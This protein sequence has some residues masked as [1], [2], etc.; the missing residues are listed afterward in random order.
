MD[1]YRIAPPPGISPSLEHSP[2]ALHLV[3]CKPQDVDSQ[4]Q[5]VCIQSRHRP[6]GRAASITRWSWVLQPMAKQPVATIRVNPLLPMC[7]TSVHLTKLGAWKITL[8]VRDR[9]GRTST[10]VSLPTFR[11]V[12]I[13]AIGDSLASGEGNPGTGWTDT[14]CHR[15]HNAWPEQVARNF[16]ENYQT[17]V[18]FLSYAC[19][20]ANLENLYRTYQNGAPPQVVAARWDIGAPKGSSTRRIDALLL[21]VGVNDLG[22]VDKQGRIEGFSSILKQCALTN[23]QRD[24]SPEFARLPGLYAALNQWIRA[25]LKVAHVYA[26]DYPAWIFTNAA[27]HFETCGVFDAMSN[28]DVS[29]VAT[30]GTASRPDPGHCGRQVQLEGH[31]DV[32]PTCFTTATAPAAPPGIA[33]GAI[34]TTSR[35]M[36]GGRRTPPI[37]VITG[38][39]NSCR[40][41]LRASSDLI[42]RVLTRRPRQRGRL[43]AP[44]HEAMPHRTS[45]GSEDWVG[46]DGPP[47]R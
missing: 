18:T 2:E 27:G 26:A 36:T 14:A 7:S 4:P 17:T 29:W 34:H 20:G 8:T 22:L 47:L 9:L 38:S 46:C 23:C 1:D 28:G 33:A 5:R 10:Y 13:V 11:D 43:D 40:R 21:S 3:V 37:T 35:E 30:P 45:T 12:L 39:P 25:N 44:T 42:R 19:S 31:G 24:L 6:S 41:G 16:V 15:S 32:G